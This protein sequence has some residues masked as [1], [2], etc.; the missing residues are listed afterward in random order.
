MPSYRGRERRTQSAGLSNLEGDGVEGART[1]VGQPDM[2]HS[3]QFKQRLFVMTL[4]LWG[5]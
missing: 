1:E 3:C 5:S 2:G 4:M